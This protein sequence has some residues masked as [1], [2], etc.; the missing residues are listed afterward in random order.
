[1]SDSIRSPGRDAWPPFTGQRRELSCAPQTHG[2]VSP[3]GNASYAA[4]PKY[5]DATFAP[6]MQPGAIPPPPCFNGGYKHPL[7]PSSTLATP[8]QGGMSHPARRESVGPARSSATAIASTPVNAHVS[9]AQWVNDNTIYATGGPSEGTGKFVP[10]AE[11]I[12]AG[13]EEAAARLARLGPAGQPS[14]RPPQ[15]AGQRPEWPLSGP[16]HPFHSRLFESQLNALDAYSA[17]KINRVALAHAL[18]TVPVPA[19][20]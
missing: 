17:A 16:A 15:G 12:K 11:D 13:Q 6:R 5:Q 20:Y 14:A 1:M 8:A 10:P 7:P 2:N 19:S 3:S 4:G 18:L 9:R